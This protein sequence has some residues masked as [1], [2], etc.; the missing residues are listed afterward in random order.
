MD[1]NRRKMQQTLR[2]IL[3][4]LAT[5]GNAPGFWNLVKAGLR[6]VNICL[7]QWHK[8]VKCLDLQP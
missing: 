6:P 2:L 7:I 5:G 1:I 4:T 3:L 8:V